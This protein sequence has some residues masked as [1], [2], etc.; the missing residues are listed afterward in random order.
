MR[1]SPETPPPQLTHPV[2]PSPCKKITWKRVGD[3]EEGSH[4]PAIALCPPA[5]GHPSLTPEDL[6]AGGP[7]GAAPC[8][9]AAG[10]LPPITAT[11]ILPTPTPVS[12]PD[13]LGAAWGR[14]GPLPQLFP[15]QLQTQ[16]QRR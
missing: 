8:L 7:E 14:R 2:S 16:W 5:S 10:L 6:G 4:H 15:A 3:G 11:S 1:A 12:S 9:L 13:G